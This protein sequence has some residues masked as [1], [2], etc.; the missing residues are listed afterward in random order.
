MVAGIGSGH[1]NGVN[2]IRLAKVSGRAEGQ[3]NSELPGRGARLLKVAA[4]KSADLSILSETE[5]G[6]KAAHCMQTES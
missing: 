4:R 5:S 1:E 3:R 2:F 6:H